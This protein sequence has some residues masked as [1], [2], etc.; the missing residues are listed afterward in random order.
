MPLRCVSSG[1]SHVEQRN[2]AIG[3]S[4][5]VWVDAQGDR[6]LSG[7]GASSCKNRACDSWTRQ[8]AGSSGCG[9]GGEFRTYTAQKLRLSL[10]GGPH[11]SGSRQRR[12]EFR[13]CQFRLEQLRFPPKGYHTS[14]A[15]PVVWLCMY[16]Y[17]SVYRFTYM[18]YELWGVLMYACSGGWVM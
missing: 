2:S 9:G 10:K 5:R 7:Y 18:V 3:L 11:R 1:L 6:E 15:H 17:F 8:S 4:K 16:L 14:T 12:C 13:R